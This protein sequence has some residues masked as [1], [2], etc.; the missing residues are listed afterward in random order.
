MLHEEEKKEKPPIS[1]LK[2]AQ[3]TSV[4]QM[5]KNAEKVVEIGPKKEKKKKISQEFTMESKGETITK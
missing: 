3:L 4:V 2:K 5:K 1:Q